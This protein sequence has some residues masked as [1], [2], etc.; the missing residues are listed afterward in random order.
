MAFIFFSQGKVQDLSN[1][2]K[3]AKHNLESA[4]QEL[5]EYKEKAT[6]ILQVHVLLI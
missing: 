3:M 2:L 6:R 5:T 4:K 1:Q